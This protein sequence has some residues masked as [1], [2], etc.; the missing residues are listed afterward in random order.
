MTSRLV[1]LLREVLA[2][3]PKFRVASG[4]AWGQ[5]ASEPC[6]SMC[7][8]GRT[9]LNELGKRGVALLWYLNLLGRFLVGVGCGGVESDALDGEKRRVRKAYVDWSTTVNFSSLS[10]QQ[11]LFRK[12]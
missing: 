11:A 2:P 12:D 7:Y 9:V 6:S 1:Y 3:I 5:S 10:W 8:I 4:I